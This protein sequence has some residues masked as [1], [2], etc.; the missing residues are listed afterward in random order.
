[1]SRIRV[2]VESPFAGRGEI[3]A[4]DAQLNLAYLDAVCRHLSLHGYAPFASHSFY[5]R[6]L[7]DSVPEER[8]IGIEAGLAWGAAAECSIV[9]VDRGISKGM[10]YGME[11]ALLDG[12]P[13]YFLSLAKWADSVL[14]KGVDREGWRQY[15]DHL[16]NLVRV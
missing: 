10:V 2:L 15:S 7:V 11:R 5:T 1:M 4:R 12:R 13:L 3:K 6:F 16:W 9:A 8:E 14:P